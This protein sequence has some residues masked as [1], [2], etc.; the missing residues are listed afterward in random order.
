MC[1]TYNSYYDMFK[2][3]QSGMNRISVQF[4][5]TINFDDVL[6]FLN[7]E[8]YPRFLFG[9]L[10][11]RVSIVP[12]ALVWCCVDPKASILES[13][14]N[15]FPTQHNSLLLFNEV[16]DL[17]TPHAI[18]SVYDKRFIQFNSPGRASTNVFADVDTH[19][20]VPY[21]KYASF[22]HKDITLRCEQINVQELISYLYGYALKDTYK[23]RAIE[24]YSSNPWVVP[25]EYI[26]NQPFTNAP[27]TGGLNSTTTF[28]L[29]GAKAIAFIFPELSTELTVFK[30]PYLRDCSITINS[31]YYT[32]N[33]VDTTSSQFLRLMLQA[34]NLDTIFTCTESFENSYSEIEGFVYPIKGV[35]YGDNTDFMFM[36]PLERGSATPFYYDGFKSNNGT[37][38]VKISGVF[39]QQINPF[40]PDSTYNKV[41]VNNYAILNR[42]DKEPNKPDPDNT[43]FTVPTKYNNT[44]PNILIITDSFWVFQIGKLP[45]YYCNGREFMD[46]LQSDYPAKFSQ[47]VGTIKEILSHQ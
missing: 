33:K 4:P 22:S 26:V 45:K 11:L 19:G 14:S 34:A 2:Q 39:L 15:F 12:N 27:T 18:H 6:H 32:Y 36:V 47:L 28:N 7:F 38:T 31:K 3:Q 37:D 16:A 13:E 40:V 25:S 9:N 30:N 5:I 43:N 46:I 44:A 17:V 29:K 10:S 21:V 41:D 42:Y 20:D 35:T 8:D 23:Q 1:G 24:Y